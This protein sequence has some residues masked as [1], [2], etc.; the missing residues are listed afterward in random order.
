M[1]YTSERA[2][3]L[4]GRLAVVTGAASGIGRATALVFAAAGARVVA[5]DIDEAGLETLKAENDRIVSHR[6][7]LTD[8]AAIDDL[9]AHALELGQPD[10]WVNVAGTGS[11]T[12]ISTVSEADYERVVAI[13]MTAAYWCCAAA[14]RIMIRAPNA[15]IVNV[16]S[17]AADQPIS[18]LSAYAMTKSALNM[19]TRTLATELGPAG[20][21]VNA[22][23][24]GFTVTPMTAGAN[25]NEEERDALIERNAAR[26]PLGAVGR[27]EDIALAILYLAAPASQFVTGQIL[28]VNGGSCM[29]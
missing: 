21:R 10:C 15:A 19:L 7:D 14:S 27:P 2:F 28:R 1:A 8:K 22:V 13:N 4:D 20:I 6:C 16:S 23:A 9:A 25:L 26:S 18:G 3:R 24:P 17:N 5:S 29:P 11:L 12:P